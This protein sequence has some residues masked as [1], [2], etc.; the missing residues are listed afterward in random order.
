MT[1]LSPEIYIP[2]NSIPLDKQDYNFQ[3][4]IGLQGLPKSGKTWSALGFSNPVVVSFDRGL[5]SHI[6]KKEIIEIPFYNEKF[7]DSVVSR[8]ST[9]Y[10]DFYTGVSKLRPCNRK[11]ALTKWLYTEAVKLTKNQ[12]LIL[13]GLTGID[14]AYHGEYWLEPAVD[15][16]GKLKPYEEY[17]RKKDYLTEIAMCIKALTCDII[18]ICHESFDRNEK[19]DLNGMI[20]PLMSGQ[21]LDQL[22][23]HFTDWFRCITVEKPIEEKKMDFMKAFR[24]SNIP[25]F[26]EWMASTDTQTIYLWQTQS[27]QHAQCGTSLVGAPKYI[28]AHAN[29]FEKY[30][31]TNQKQ[32]I[33]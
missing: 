33:V 24:I 20:R 10:N 12:T 7:V 3:R 6:G 23:S 26:Q 13:D 18:L 17:K 19:G 22:Q 9:H 21:F 5:L 30:K 15:R 11:D 29:S 28:L 32:N 31:Q 27:D 16:E 14:A 25:Q 2:T 8:V 4:R 1:A